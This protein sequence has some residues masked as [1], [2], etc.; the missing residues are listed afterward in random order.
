[1]E[2]SPKSKK[3]VQWFHSPDSFTD[4]QI[5]K[6][7]LGAWLTRTSIHSIP[8]GEFDEAL[9]AALYV[10]IFLSSVVFLHGISLGLR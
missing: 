1:M 5:E 4:A 3:Q 9:G 10:C 8:D 2:K 7:G 6:G